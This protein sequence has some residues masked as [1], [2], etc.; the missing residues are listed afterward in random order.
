M[1]S[2]NLVFK[3]YRLQQIDSQLDQCHAR[4]QEIETALSD[5]KALRKA[6][7]LLEKSVD[8]LEIEKKALR[9]TEHKTQAQRLKIKQTD[10][11]LYGGRVTNPKELQDLQNESLSLKRYLEV[12]EERQLVAMLS[13]DEAESAMQSAKATFDQEQ[14]KTI[15]KNAALLGEQTALKNDVMRRQTEHMAATKAIPEGE[16]RTYEKLRARRGGVAVAKVSDKSCTACGSILPPALRQE[17][18]SPNQ[19]AYCPDCG[20]IIYSN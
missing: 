13:L 15:E 8:S 14:A 17:A 20:R 12:L 9:Q 1:A 10:T 16:L 11:N 3:L 18:R 6:Q 19:I 7:S 4:L 5:E 2:I